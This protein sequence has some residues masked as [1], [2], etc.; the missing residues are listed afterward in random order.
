M[1][2]RHFTQEYASKMGKR[3][4]SIG[5]RMLTALQHYPWPG[6]IRELR[7]V[8]ELAVILTQGEELAFIDWGPPPKGL[9][10]SPVPATLDEAERAHI[11]KVLSATGWRIAGPNGAAEI[12]GLPST[13]LRSRMEKLGIKKP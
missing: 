11:L 5:E 3:I 10:E 12:L 8:I 6:N 9:S 7:H 2:A 13:T 4:A 1:L